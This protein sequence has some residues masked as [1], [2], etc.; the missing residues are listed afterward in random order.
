MTN[1]LKILLYTACCAISFNNCC[2][3][4][5]EQ[6]ETF[7]GV[8]IAKNDL[9]IDG[10]FD[11]LLQQISQINKNKLFPYKLSNEFTYTKYQSIK[12]I[13]SSHDIQQRFHSYCIAQYK[14]F[15]SKNHNINSLTQLINQLLLDT[16]T[17][18]SLYETDNPNTVGWQLFQVSWSILL[19]YTSKKQQLSSLH[20]KLSKLNDNVLSHVGIDTSSINFTSHF[21]S[22]PPL[23]ND[24]KQ[25]V[26]SSSNL[27]NLHN[28]KLNDINNNNHNNSNQIH[29][30]YTNPISY[31]PNSNTNNNININQINNNNPTIQESQNINP[32]KLNLSPINKKS[33]NINHNNIIPT[34]PKKD[35]P[36]HNNININLN[37]NNNNNDNNLNFTPFNNKP[38]KTNLNKINL[39]NQQYQIDSQLVD[40]WHNCPNSIQTIFP[41]FL[42]T[43]QQQL[44]TYQ[45]NQ[46]MYNKF[47][48]QN[49]LKP[50]S[51]SLIRQLYQD[52]K[53]ILSNPLLNTENTCNLFKLA[54]SILYYYYIL[55]AWEFDSLDMSEI[56][57]L[58]TFIGTLQTI[59]DLSLNNNQNNINLQNNNLITN[60]VNPSTNPYND[61]GN[62]KT[63]NGL[64]NIG[65]TCYMNATLQ[66]FINLTDFGRELWDIVHNNNNEL[67]RRTNFT[68]N[69]DTA[70][71]NRL[72]LDFVDV[73]NNVKDKNNKSKYFAP[74]QFKTTLANSNELF[75]GIA[76]ND[77]KDLINYL[78]MTLH[79]CLNE[80][81]VKQ[82]N[83][84]NN[85][86]LQNPAMQKNQ[87]LMWNTFLN[88]FKSINNS[89]VSRNFYAF[90]CTTTTCSV[91]NTTLYNYQIYFF[92]IF[93]LEEVRRYKGKETHVTLDD[94]FE[95]DQKL[96]YMNGENA[97]YCNY[98]KKSCN[99]SMQTKLHNLPK[100]LI[101]ILNKGQGLQFN[102]QLKDIPQIVDFNKYVESKENNSR[103]FLS[104]IVNHLGESGMSGHFIAY[105][106]QSPNHNWVMYNDAT[107]KEI[108][109][110]AEGNIPKDNKLYKILKG[111]VNN[112]DIPYILFYTR[113]DD[114]K[115]YLGNKTKLPKLQDIPPQN[116]NVPFPN[117]PNQIMNNNNNM[118]MNPMMM[119][120]MMQFMNMKIMPQMNG[121]NNMNNMGNN[122]MMV[123]NNNMNFNNRNISNNNF[124]SNNNQRNIINN[125]FNNMGNNNMMMNNNM[126]RMN[127]NN[128]NNFNQMNNNNMMMNKGNQGNN[129][130]MNNMNPNMNMN[131][132]MNVNQNNNMNNNNMN[133]MNFNNGNNFNNN[134]NNNN[135]N[136]N[137]NFNNNNMNNF[138]NNNNFQ[139]NQMNNM[140][141][142]GNNNFINNNFQ[143]NQ[144]NNMSN[145]NNMMMN[146]N[147]MN[148]NNFK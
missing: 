117:M 73:I 35:S 103:Y 79:E 57:E 114:N 110:D 95:Y 4:M 55:N 56:N 61:N 72:V 90:N 141:N 18:I 126:N 16:V 101:I 64:E 69:R 127:F 20:S 88:E 120:N 66:C 119:Q 115:N 52:T 77:S 130:I 133:Q 28:I 5:E 46:T 109:C 104:G 140:N 23:I 128:G 76:A 124:I 100:N 65:A 118:M 15:V 45:F 92:L 144:F 74:H 146:N 84:Q 29:N 50:N 93:P 54:W 43:N 41:N 139:N 80:R 129:I 85:G 27:H 96:N 2:Y 60:T 78:I 135:M 17:F 31:N 14:Q 22:I 39:S 87:Q 142:I 111:E 21:E 67:Q 36:Q 138:N 19:Q 82:N 81:S 145:N 34:N 38:K 30:S 148:M 107:T 134:M 3:S 13:L 105:C 1:T 51:D 48:S 33:N 147:N 11:N 108:K 102:V 98:C 143:N 121:M 86:I 25:I 136:F 63:Q 62:L 70:I 53:N 40:T 99:S 10:N 75:K 112:D 68:N 137:N 9:T 49:M 37:S 32:H 71:T 89:V 7:C 113:I 123:N 59:K 116:N 94:C 91:C 26:T 125:G 47:E 12:N 58:K 42:N 131:Q 83:T 97:M 24:S 6:Y 132:N 44:F 106:R 8:K 122:N